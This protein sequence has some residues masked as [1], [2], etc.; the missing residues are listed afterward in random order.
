MGLD[1]SI[2][3][4]NKVCSDTKELRRYIAL[5]DEVFK[6]GYKHHNP[7]AML[8]GLYTQEYIEGTPKNVLRKDLNSILN[9]IKHRSID[10]DKVE[11]KEVAYFRKW[12]PLK[13]Q[14]EEYYD[15]KKEGCSFNFYGR[16]ILTKEIL[17]SIINRI[18]DKNSA[19]WEDIDDI[20]KTEEYQH[21]IYE[22]LRTTDFSKETLYA[23][24]WE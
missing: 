14:C 7:K 10:V 12:F 5:Q 23:I 19:Y 1:F 6:S 17:E 15:E 16:L 20:E 9:Y 2:Y 21:K 11:A 8:R 4:T 22:L 24:Y 18:E 3:K 13:W